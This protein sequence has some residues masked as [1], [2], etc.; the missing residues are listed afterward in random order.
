M[1][2]RRYANIFAKKQKNLKFYFENDRNYPADTYWNLYDENKKV[3]MRTYDGHIFC[4]LCKLAP[5]TVAHGNK[6]RY[7]KVSGSNMEKHAANCSYR[8]DKAT[9]KEV[10]SFYSDLNNDDINNRLVS[11]INK[12]LKKERTK[13]NNRKNVD[14]KGNETR[15]SFCDIIGKGGKNKYLPHKNFNCGNLEIDLD[16][17]KIYYGRCFLYIVKYIPKNENEVKMYY[18]KV[19]SP[20]NK[21]QICE[22]IISPFIYNYLENELADVPTEKKDAAKYYLCF[23]GIL[24]KTKWS[25]ALKLRDSR[26]IVLEKA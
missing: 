26:L 5:L 11:C 16:E 19:L 7:F 2:K 10:C 21:R 14:Y 24:E 22:I 17:Q 15:R 1:F 8:Y 18:L 13:I 6:L 4:P 20:D 23:A 12:M 3:A 9:K 25:Y